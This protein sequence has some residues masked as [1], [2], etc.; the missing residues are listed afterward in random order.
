MASRGSPTADS[1]VSPLLRLG[2]EVDGV[3]VGAVALPLGLVLLPQAAGQLCCHQLAAAL[4]QDATEGLHLLN[5]ATTPLGSGRGFG[6]N[7][8]VCVSESLS[9]AGMR[10]G[11]YGPSVA[12]FEPCPQ[13]TISVHRHLTPRGVSSVFPE[14]WA[15]FRGRAER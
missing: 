6:V 2:L 14:R 8:V 3:P 11:F 9:W 5:S 13:H 10:A 15:P 12:I 1:P 4:L 7:S